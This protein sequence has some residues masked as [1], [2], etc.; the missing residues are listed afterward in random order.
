MG[1]LLSL[2]HTRIG[3]L[4]GPRTTFPRSR[5]LA[6]AR[7]IAA[8]AAGLPIPT[9][10]HRPLA[11]LAR[12]CPGRR[13]DRLIRAGVTGIVCASDPMALGRDPG[14]PP[15]RPDVPGDV[16]VVGFDDSALMNCTDPPLTTV[17]QPIEPM[18]RLVIELLVAPDRRQRRV[19]HDEMLFEPELVVRSLDR[20]R[21]RLIRRAAQPAQ[22]IGSVKFLHRISLES[23]TLRAMPSIAR[24]GA[25][26]EGNVTTIERPGPASGH[27]SRASLDATRGRL[28]RADSRWWRTAV[29][30]QV[31]LRSFADGNGDG[32]GDLAGVRSRLPVP[33]RPRRRR[34]VVHA[35]VRLAA[36]RRW[37]RRRR[38]PG[39][40]PGLRDARRG[41]GADRRG[42]GARHPDDRRRRSQPRVRAS[43]R[44]SRPP[45]LPRLARPSERASGSTPGAAT[46]AREMPTDWVSN[47]GRADLD[48][49]DRT[50]TGR[51]GEWYLHLFSAD[52]PDLNWNHPDVRRE[53]EDVLGFW[54]DR[55]AAGV[56]IDSA[57][58][59]VKDA[60]AARGP[61]RTRA[62][63][64][65]EHGP[66][67]APRHLSELA[68]GRR[69]AIRIRRS[70]SASSGCPTSSGSP[71]TCART[72]STPR[73][74]S[75]SS[76]GRGTPPSSPRLDRRDARG[77]CPGRRPGDVA[78]VE[79]RRD[80]AGDP[81]RPRRTRR[82]RSWPSG[83]G[84]RPTSPSG[85]RRARA[86]ALLAAALPGS[87]YIYQGDELG[88]DEVEDLPGDRI[89]DPMH[90]RS[91]G[92]GPGPRRLPRAAAVVRATAAVR[93]Q[94]GGATRRAVAA[95]AGALGRADR[96]GPGAR[97]GFDAH[98]Y[99]AALGIRR[100]DPDLA[101]GARST[102]L[103][104]RRRRPR[105]PARRPR[106]SRITNLSAP[107]RSPPPADAELLLA[108]ARPGR[109]PAA[110]ATPP[111]GGG[112]RRRR[113]EPSR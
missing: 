14:G 26:P 52:Q 92:V 71:A 4:L 39:D 38:L 60:D 20:S 12:G 61:A 49:D 91:G 50:P 97:S 47:F 7:A 103:P 93:L 107:R 6:A 110:D 65:S 109:R 46:T 53:H 81:V 51:P 56:R 73:S 57:A 31:Y 88:L 66:R 105:V 19:A 55:G 25:M 69:L 24:R 45:S 62:R 89:Q 40:R 94:P 10:P 87:L 83:R 42:P 59:L 54:F 108:S 13:A 29:I 99:R 3:L 21:S 98:L 74:T 44:G 32:I 95:A 41:G 63:D 36:G 68:R 8:S 9:G 17:R 111:P 86:A 70:S 64:A 112:T 15:R 11:V 34:A 2:G 1:H 80:P 75:T 84:R 106:S 43:T 5:K 113:W 18:G 33:P 27:R 48:A 79:P 82:S 101:D 37:L 104:V 30:Y 23:V 72:S 78:P 90:F 102:W 76:P 16:S 100:A 58:L 96:R 67:R 77:P 85:R 35:L 22:S 28:S